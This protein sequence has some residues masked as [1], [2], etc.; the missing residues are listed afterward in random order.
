M[1]SCRRRASRRQALPPPLTRKARD[2]SRFHASS[3]K[4]SSLLGCARPPSHLLRPL[5]VVE[6]FT[7]F[8]SDGGGDVRHA[9]VVGSSE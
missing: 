2:L 7:E 3:Y 9:S 6:F 4:A 5:A 8:E 1:P